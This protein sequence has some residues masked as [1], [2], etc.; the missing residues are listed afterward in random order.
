MMPGPHLVLH[1]AHPSPDAAV[2]LLADANAVFE[3]LLLLGEA[4]STTS[5][6]PAPPPQALTTQ[7]I[8]HGFGLQPFVSV[9]FSHSLP[10]SFG[11]IIIV[12]VLACVPLPHDLE[13]GA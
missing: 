5:P 7:F 9:S 1:F 2:E 10:P 8:G 6:L 3:L 12:L 4:A 13:H 11:R